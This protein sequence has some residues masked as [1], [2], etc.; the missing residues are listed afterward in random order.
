MNGPGT[1]DG[2]GG[3]GSGTRRAGQ[4]PGFLYFYGGT[5]IQATGNSDDVHEKNIFKIAQPLSWQNWNRVE[6]KRTEKLDAEIQHMGGGP[7]TG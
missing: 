3:K 4:E 5:G 6:S 2:S 7:L 1:H